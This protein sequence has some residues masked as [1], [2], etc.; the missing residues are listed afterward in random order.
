MP[1]IY[2]KAFPDEN[3]QKVRGLGATSGR[4]LICGARTRA[5]ATIAITA[6]GRPRTNTGGGQSMSQSMSPRTSGRIDPFQIPPWPPHSGPT[7]EKSTA[8]SHDNRRK[9]RRPGDFGRGL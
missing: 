7:R 3:G 5:I 9:V 4:T 6:T 2:L 8:F 1:H